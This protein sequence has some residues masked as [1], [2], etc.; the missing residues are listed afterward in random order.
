[1]L[2]EDLRDL[3]TV[4]ANLAND[5]TLHINEIHNIL[6][7]MPDHKAIEDCNALIMSLIKV[8][9]ISQRIT[10][11]SGNKNVQ[12]RNAFKEKNKTT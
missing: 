5:A 1:M 3:P 6:L 7:Q 10:H 8:K 9:D 11:T 2:K 4:A 12:I